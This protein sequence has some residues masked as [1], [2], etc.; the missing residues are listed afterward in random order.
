MYLLYC[1]GLFTG[2]SSLTKWY[3]IT[4]H[5]TWILSIAVY[6]LTEAF[7]FRNRPSTRGKCYGQV[8]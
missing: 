5:N 7:F 8:S 4:T 3:S 1:L 6:S 2:H